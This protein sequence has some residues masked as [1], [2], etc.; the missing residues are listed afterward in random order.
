MLKRVMI[1]VV[2]VGF[3]TQALP[4]AQ[5]KD[6]KPQ[7]TCPVTGEP[8]KDLAKAAK[9]VYKGKTYYFCCPACKPKFDKDPEKYLGGSGQKAGK[10]SGHQGHDKGHEQ[11]A[12]GSHCGH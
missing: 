10:S 11:C 6:D 5:A 12:P 9:S 8:V 7:V 1:A 3:L 4:G 2:A